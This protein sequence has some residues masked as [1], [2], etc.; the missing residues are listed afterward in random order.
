MATRL[1]VSVVSESC[2]DLLGLPGAF[3][4]RVAVLA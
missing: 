2:G 4:F 3:A 1:H